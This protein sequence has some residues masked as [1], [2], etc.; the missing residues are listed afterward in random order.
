[1]GGRESV[2]RQATQLL[3]SGHPA[4]SL[5]YL[6]LLID[7]SAGHS[8]QNGSEGVP[9]EEDLLGGQLIEQ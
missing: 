3:E 9:L 6:D 1:M 2:R 8:E 5:N 7:F 4:L